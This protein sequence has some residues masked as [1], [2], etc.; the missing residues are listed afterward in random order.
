MSGEGRPCT[1]MD[2]ELTSLAV[3]WEREHRSWTAHLSQ[4]GDERVTSY[5]GPW[6]VTVT[7]SGAGVC[8]VSVDDLD[9][10]DVWPRKELDAAVC[11]GDDAVEVTLRRVPA[12][13][14]WK[15]EHS[16]IGDL[17]IA[18][19][20]EQDPR[21]TGFLLLGPSAEATLELLKSTGQA[22]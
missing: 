5:A 16:L 4:G 17:F 14:I 8:R 10:G 12:E 7:T 13:R 6:L 3:L 11:L 2:Q 20:G 15:F 19:S 18:D 9:G 22:R 21:I 1:C